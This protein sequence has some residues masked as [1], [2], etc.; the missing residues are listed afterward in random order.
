MFGVSRYEHEWNEFLEVVETNLEEY[1][2]IWYLEE[3]DTYAKEGAS[4]KFYVT[5]VKAEGNEWIILVTE[6]LDEAIEAARNHWNSLT[7]HDK[8]RS[9][10]EVRVYKEDVEDDDCFCFDYDTVSWQEAHHG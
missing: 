8:K 1:E 6:D 5:D 3:V 2:R 7:S 4:M 10:I 9:T